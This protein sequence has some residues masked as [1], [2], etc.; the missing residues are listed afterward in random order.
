MFGLISV[1]FL[2]MAYFVGK[3]IRANGQKI[4]IRQA[5]GVVGIVLAATGFIYSLLS[6][7]GAVVAVVLGMVLGVLTTIGAVVLMMILNAIRGKDS[8]R[9]VPW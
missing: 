6:G 2:V 5:A 4:T 7:D 9:Y 1:P 8:S 3:R